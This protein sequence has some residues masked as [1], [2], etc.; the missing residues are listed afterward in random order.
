MEGADFDDL[1]LA[2]GFVV[3]I[4][5]YRGPLG[6]SVEPNVLVSARSRLLPAVAA[7]IGL[8]DTP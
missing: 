5:G 8:V 4:I 3:G 2:V 1:A 7:A 6:G